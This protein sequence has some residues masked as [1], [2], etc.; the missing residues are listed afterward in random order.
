M[1]Q[2]WRCSLIDGSIPI[3]LDG[4][5]EIKEE[6]KMTIYRVVTRFNWSHPM[7]FV[8]GSIDEIEKLYKK[9]YPDGTDIIMIEHIE[10]QVISKEPSD[11]D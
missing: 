8:V 4:K 3:C 9:K 7:L 11:G 10:G 2:G 5:L 1:R 6:E